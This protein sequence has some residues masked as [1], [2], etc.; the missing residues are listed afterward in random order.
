MIQTFNIPEL[1]HVSN[2]LVLRQS[3]K[4]FRMFCQTVVLHLPLLF[5]YLCHWSQP[6]K[7]FFCKLPRITFD[8]ITLKSISNLVR[9]YLWSNEIC[10]KNIQFCWTLYF[11]AACRGG[12]QIY[13]N[14]ISLYFLLNSFITVKYKAF[15][16][17][18]HIV[19]MKIWPPT[20]QITF[21]AFYKGKMAP[22]RLQKYDFHKLSEN[23][24]KC[25]QMRFVKK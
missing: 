7:P 10:Q 2:T 21:L 14:D 4:Q 18:H 22:K 17:K 24:P 20:G 3:F 6:C 8:I 9:P 23:P 1:L 15:H 12:V 16:Q 13:Q 11:D 19:F 25:G 5:T